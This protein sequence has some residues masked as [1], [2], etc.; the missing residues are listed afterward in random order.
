MPSIS[1]LCTL[2][3]IVRSVEVTKACFLL[4]IEVE[5]L[6]RRVDMAIIKGAQSR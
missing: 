4:F 1:L 2:A 3:N 6:G 5:L